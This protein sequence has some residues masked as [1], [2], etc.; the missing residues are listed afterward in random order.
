M[1]IRQG[2]SSEWDGVRLG[3]PYTVIQY[4]RVDIGCIP[5]FFTVGVNGGRGRNLK[6]YTLLEKD[7][8]TFCPAIK[9]QS[10]TDNTKGSK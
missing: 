1:L 5:F 7:S 3:Q 2:L 9:F 8:K 4:L 6:N 10:W